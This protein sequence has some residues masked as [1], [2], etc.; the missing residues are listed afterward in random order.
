MYSR[1][2]WDALVKFNIQNKPSGIWYGEENFHNVNSQLRIEDWT[3]GESFQ[4]RAEAR[5]WEAT[6][7]E[8]C[9]SPPGAQREPSVLWGLV[10]SVAQS[11]R[12]LYDPMDCSPLGSSVHGILQARI[13]EW[14]A[15]SSSRGSS[16]PQLEPMP[17]GS[18]FSTTQTPGNVTI[19]GDGMFL[20]S[21][22]R[23]VSPPASMPKEKGGRK[24]QA[25]LDFSA[26]MKGKSLAGSLSRKTL[27]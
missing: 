14:V 23:M 19:C 18:E 10:C 26:S 11:C 15:I 16:C 27:L 5:E 12:T 17:P 25:W 2:Y 20:Q 22:G 24:S 21:G 1:T 8:R 9:K 7:L 13:L 6:G 3:G 4:G